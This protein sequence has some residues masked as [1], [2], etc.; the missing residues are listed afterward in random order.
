MYF[1]AYVLMLAA[2]VCALGGGCFALLQLWQGRSELLAPIEKAH[3]LSAAALLFASALL[4]HGLYYSDFSLQYVTSY[5]DRLLPVFYRLTAFWAGQAGS[6]LFWALA[7]ALA[8]AAFLL[9]PGYRRLHPS[10]RL[11]F[12]LFFSGIMS[13]FGLLLTSWSNPFLMH[14]PTPPD[15]NGLNPL[16]QNPGMIFHPPLLF[17]GYGGFVVPGCLA[18][19]QH[20]SGKRDEEGGWV[21]IARPFTLLAWL[22][23]TAGIVLGAWW[24]YMEL[25]WGGYWAWDPVENASLIPWLI[26][27]AALHV[28]LLEERRGKLAKVNVALMSLTTISAFFATWLV[29]SGVI[30]S[31]HAFGDGGVGTPLLIF[32]ALG[33]ALCLWTAFFGPEEQRRLSGLDSREGLLV[34]AI[35]VLLVLSVVI[36]TATLWPVLSKIWGAQAQGLSQD[37]YNRVCLPLFALL[38]LMLAVCPLLRWDRGIRSKGKSLAV[39]VALVGSACL[40]WIFGYRQPTALVAA[41]AACAVAG[42]IVLLLAERPGRSA[43]AACGVHLG[44]ALTVLGAAFSGPYKQE[45]DF[46]LGENE[47]A[48]LGA[49]EIRL[50]DITDGENPGHHFL[51]ARLEVYKNGDK[52]G[53]V[54]PRRSIHAKF[55]NQQFAEADTVFSLGDEIYASLLGLTLRPGMPKRVTVKIGI[56]P[57]VN[58]L[59]IGGTLMCLFPLAAL[60]RRSAS[61]ETRSGEKKSRA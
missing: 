31:V 32:V 26:G 18:L 3:I 20:L 14:S 2:M 27:T 5:T 41:S 7:V 12:L 59:W 37:F 44:V 10:T 49:Y 42:G 46:T 22:L 40:L 4:L 15:G 13:F 33:T 53:E 47:R 35:W 25:G 8:G 28:S 23:L 58:W 56:H 57:L 24:A 6:L 52:T 16:L 61:G 21:G 50:T 36:L 9:T 45:A 11:W 55:G 60:R 29:R 1:F 51:E 19:A 54:A 17:L 48:T 30:E 39:C 43:L 38:T 34:S